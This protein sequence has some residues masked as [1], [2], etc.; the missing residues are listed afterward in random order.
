MVEVMAQL[1][2]DLRGF[3]IG[4]VDGVDE[5]VQLEELLLEVRGRVPHTNKTIRTQI[6]EPSCTKGCRK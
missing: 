3:E 6:K 4:V 2:V 1:A 5:G